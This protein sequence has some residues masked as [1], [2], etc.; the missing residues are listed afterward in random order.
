MREKLEMLLDELQYLK[1]EGINSVYYEDASLE[2]LKKVVN[3]SIDGEVKIH[4]AETSTPQSVQKPLAPAKKLNPFSP[5]PSDIEDFETKTVVEKSSSPL[6]SASR[7]KAQPQIP[8]AIE[9][10]VRIDLP[11][12]DKQI[13]WNFLHEKAEKAFNNAILNKEAKAGSKMIFGCG[14]LDSDIFFCGDSPGIEEEIEGMP[15]GGESGKLLAKIVQAMGLRKEN[16]YLANIIN[17]ILEAPAHLGERTPTQQELSASLPYLKAQIEIIK[18]KVIV[19]LGAAAVNGLL[20]PDKSRKMGE[21]RGQWF[22]FQNIPLMI[23]FHPSYLIRN[24]TMRTKRLVWEDM[25]SI[26]AR[27]GLPIS[28]KQQGFFK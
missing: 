9:P 2:Q 26:M 1:K 17:W 10:T 4:R 6:A 5:L 7:P 21:V 27:L 24:N 25:L 8:R 3:E 11:K 23:T 14:S 12:G 28:E 15:F 18:P 16:V 13:Q 20:G 19:A 22:E